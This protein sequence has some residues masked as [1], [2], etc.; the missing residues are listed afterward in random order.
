MRKRPNV[1]RSLGWDPGYHEV[2]R[3]G[4]ENKIHKGKSR[5]GVGEWFRCFHREHSRRS[6]NVRHS[7]GGRGTW[8]CHYMLE[9]LHHVLSVI[10]VLNKGLNQIPIWKV[11]QQ[12]L[13]VKLPKQETVGN[14]QEELEPTWRRSWTPPGRRPAQGRVGEGLPPSLAR[15]APSHLYKEGQGSLLAHTSSYPLN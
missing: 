1:V 12:S 10:A 7:G 3:N 4:P 14:K 2:I 9:W 5:F 6:R 15:Q 8:M 13:K 11:K